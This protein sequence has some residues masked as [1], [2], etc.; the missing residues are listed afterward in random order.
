MLDV[1]VVAKL[2]RKFIVAW[3]WSELRPRRIVNEGLSVRNAHFSTSSILIDSKFN[4]L[5]L[6]RTG[7]GNFINPRIPDK[8]LNLSFLDC[9]AAF[10]IVTV[11]N[12]E[13]IATPSLL[14]LTLY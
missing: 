14:V 8:S 6:V 3:S 12:L 2:R 13:R 1:G 10:P 9:K 7:S 5:V 11:L 4:W